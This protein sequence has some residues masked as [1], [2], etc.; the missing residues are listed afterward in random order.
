MTIYAVDLNLHV[1]N[2]ERFELL[3]HLLRA[4]ANLDLI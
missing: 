1:D 3:L 2:I 4:K